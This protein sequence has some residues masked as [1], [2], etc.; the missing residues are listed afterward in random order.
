MCDLFIFNIVAKDK[1]FPEKYLKDENRIEH[2]WYLSTPWL[3]P[4]TKY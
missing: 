1:I 4:L 2:K 3:P